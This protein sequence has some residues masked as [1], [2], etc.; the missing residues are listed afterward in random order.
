MKKT[1]SVDD[2]ISSETRWQDELKILRRLL[3][4]SELVECVKWGAPCYTINGQ[5]VVGMM[6]FKNY[7]GI[8]FHQGVFLKDK[9]GVLVNAQEGRTK[10][11]RQWR[12]SST[13][14]INPN[15]V[16]TYVEEAIS[17]AKA[18]RKIK[19]S[20][21]K[22]LIIPIELKTALAANKSAADKFEALRSG[23]KREFADYISE[24]KR[25]ETKTRRLEKIL[26]MIK[27]GIGL[28][29]QYKK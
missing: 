15:L 22:P 19:P 21:A 6:G 11:L 10:A 17:H 8:W 25:D 12:M 9:A 3:T 28:N 5:N 18:G 7:F 13:E 2:Y 29:D 23:M 1:K 24:A 16:K 26:P 20:R 27:D 4:D 14:E